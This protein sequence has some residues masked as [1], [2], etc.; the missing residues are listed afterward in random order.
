VSPA[1]LSGFAITLDDVVVSATAIIVG[2]GTV[3]AARCV[4]CDF[5]AFVRRVAPSSGSS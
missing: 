2:G 3:S 1:T 4:E 5:V